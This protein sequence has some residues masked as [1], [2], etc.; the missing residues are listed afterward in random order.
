MLPSDKI[1]SKDRHVA[2]TLQAGVHVARVAKV[3]ESHQS[4]MLG[5]AGFVLQE[6][7]RGKGNTRV[8]FKEAH[9]HSS[10]THT[11]TTAFAY[12]H[13]HM[14]THTHAHTCTHTRIHIATARWY[15]GSVAGA[16]AI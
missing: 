9:S 5:G 3:S 14:H 15:L 6:C 7:W 1:F 10:R 2:E 8:G 11:L 12:K 13:I 4:E 16:G